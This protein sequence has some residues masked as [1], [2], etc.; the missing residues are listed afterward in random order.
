MCGAWL[1]AGAEPRQKAKNEKCQALLNEYY[2]SQGW[3]ICERM[4]EE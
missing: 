2:E 1:L 3:I 4:I